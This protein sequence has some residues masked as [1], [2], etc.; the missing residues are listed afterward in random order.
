MKGKFICPPLSLSQAERRANIICQVEDWFRSDAMSILLQALGRGQAFTG[1]DITLQAADFFSKYDFR[2]GKERAAIEENP[3]LNS[4]KAEFLQAYRDLGMVEN[5]TPSIPNP[6]HILVLGGANNANFT[7]TLKAKAICGLQEPPGTIAALSGFRVLN[8]AEREKMK[9][10]SKGK[11]EFD[12]LS[13][14][15]A[16]TFGLDTF[17]DRLFSNENINKQACVRVFDKDYRGKTVEVYAAPS[18]DPARRANTRDAFAFFLKEKKVEPGQSLVFVSNSPYANY[19]F[20]AL[21]DIAIKHNLFFDIIGD[22]SSFCSA[23]LKVTAYLQEVKA[24]S[25]CAKNF[26]NGTW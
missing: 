17:H 13:D 25:D 9:P 11:T 16:T 18:S 19:Q 1:E 5:T 8:V 3:T 21:A 23:S 20:L 6:D 26:L 10:Y 14:I 22:D 4:K 2:Q 7:R 12:V 15:I 24:T